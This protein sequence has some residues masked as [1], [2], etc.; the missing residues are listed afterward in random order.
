MTHCYKELFEVEAIVGDK[1]CRK[2]RKRL[3]LVKWVGYDDDQNT[4]EPKEHLLNV[5]D[6]VN[7]YKK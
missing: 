7:Q 4:W 2:Q 6:M 1:F 3:F 5:I